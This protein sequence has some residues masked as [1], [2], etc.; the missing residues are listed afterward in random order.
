[1]QRDGSAKA[2]WWK[3]YEALSQATPGLYGAA[4]NRGEAQTLRLSLLFA[5]LDCS[6]EIRVEHLRAGLEIW[7]FCRDSARFVFG[8]LIGDGL[9][10]TLLT[11]LRAGPEGLTLTDMHNLSGRNQSAADI[12]RALGVLSELGLAYPAHKKQEGQGRPVERWFALTV[13]GQE[14][15]IN[16]FNETNKE[17]EGIYSFNSFNSHP[18]NAAAGGRQ[19]SDTETVE[20]GDG[21]ASKGPQPVKIKI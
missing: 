20:A 3:E 2:L 16:E 19:P 12:A 18:D 15:E 10:D 11:A 8:D 5:L 4:T 7:R 9:A 14:Y 6:A 1:L 21:E 13:Q 17:G